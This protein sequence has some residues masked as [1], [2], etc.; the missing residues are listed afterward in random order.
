MI[1]GS[2]L[3]L[4]FN[5]FLILKDLSVSFRIL[6]H[7]E[8]QPKISISQRVALKNIAN[9]FQKK[10]VMGPHLRPTDSEFL[11]IRPWSL[12][13]THR[14]KRVLCTQKCKSHHITSI[15]NHLSASR[16]P[17]SPSQD[18]RRAF[19][20]AEHSAKLCIGA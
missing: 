13:V 14:K 12:I 7:S 15:H 4:T 8:G 18:F 19:D 17:S 5:N 6:S 10:N 2:L 16:E 3:V 20:L 11:R 1:S 9:C